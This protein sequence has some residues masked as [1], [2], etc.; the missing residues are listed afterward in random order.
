ML[1]YIGAYVKFL[2][3]QASVKRP[4]SIVFDCSDGVAGLVL[5][6]LKIK[7]VKIKVICGKPN[8]NFPSHG[9][10]P[11]EEGAL[12]TLKKEVKREKADLGC[13]FD[14]DGDRAFFVDNKGRTVPAYVT[15]NLLF[16]KQKGSFVTEVLTYYALKSTGFKGK[17]YE[18]RVGTYFVK[19]KMRKERSIIGGEYSGHYYF[20]ELAYSDSG[21]LTAIKVMNNLSRLPYSFADFFDSLPAFYIEQ[22]NVKSEDRKK[23]MKKIEKVYIR[24]AR[25]IDRIDGITFHFGDIWFNT[26]PS[27]TEPLLRFFIG[28]LDEK[29][30][31]KLKKEILRV[32][33]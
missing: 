24:K 30:V 4:L 27:N 15:A 29:K 25:K 22:P 8:G 13:A 2:K 26:R 9:P 11:L 10:N 3:K 18:S 21:I 6:R 32:L 5:K 19:E 31:K 17:L 20:K 1:D 23:D 12:D 14:A 16:S 7:S 28:G 33:K